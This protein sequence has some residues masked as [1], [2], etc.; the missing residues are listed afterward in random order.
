MGSGQSAFETAALLYEAGARVELIA[1]GPIIWIDRL[2]ARYTGPAKR[3]FYPP[4]EVGPA[5][6]SW[7]VAFPQFYRHLPEETR[8]AIDA[9]SVRP[10]VARW[11]RPRNRGT[12]HYH[13][14]YI[15]S[16][17]HGARARSLP[18]AQ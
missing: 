14:K 2:I 13:S 5:G 4:S 3:I 12:G 17:C 1:R 16:R 6:I 9:R 7:I 15:D 8:I 18:Q 10:A 11:M